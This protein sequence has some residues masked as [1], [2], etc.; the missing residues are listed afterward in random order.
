MYEIVVYNYTR[1]AHHITMQAIS[2]QT[3]HVNHLYPGLMQLTSMADHQ[4]LL[5][6]D[7]GWHG[8]ELFPKPAVGK[9]IE[10]SG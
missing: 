3:L 10:P 9:R 2:L 8:H 6:K 1:H 7:N 4:K 5:P